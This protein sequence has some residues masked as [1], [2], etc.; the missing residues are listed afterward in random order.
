MAAGES[1]WEPL[2]LEYLRELT[3]LLY[4]NVNVDSTIASTTID[5]LGY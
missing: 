1:F 3:R 4:P 2:Q 5:G